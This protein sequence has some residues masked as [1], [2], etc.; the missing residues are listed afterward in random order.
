MKVFWLN[1]PRFLYTFLYILMGWSIMFQKS[2]LSNIPT[3][4]F[5]WLL[6]GGISYTVGAIFYILKKPNLNK[7]WTFH[8]F[9]HLFILLGSLLMVIPCFIYI[10]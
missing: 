5:I 2:L 8:E 3:G 6:S 10:L 4:Y 9:F 7:D 1:A